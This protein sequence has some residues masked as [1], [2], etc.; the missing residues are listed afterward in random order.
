MDLLDKDLRLCLDIFLAMT[1]GSE[2]AYMNILAA[3]KCHSA[4][5]VILLHAQIK[6]CIQELIGILP[7]MTDMCVNSC[8]AFTGPFGNHTICPVCQKAHY[9]KVIQRHKLS[10]HVRNR[11]FLVPEI[12]S[13]IQEVLRQMTSLT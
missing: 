11:W 2:E 4:E 12:G 3:F 8:I 9:E 13:S 1:S 7:I 5:V 6:L 10:L